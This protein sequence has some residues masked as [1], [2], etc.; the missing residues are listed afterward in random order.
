MSL[1]GVTYQP[2]LQQARFSEVEPAESVAE[3][4]RQVCEF[5]LNL[6]QCPGTPEQLIQDSLMLKR[7][8]LTLVEGLLEL[9]KAEEVRLLTLAALA[10]GMFAGALDGALLFQHRQVPQQPTFATRRTHL[11]HPTSVLRQNLEQVIEVGRTNWGR[12]EVNDLQLLAG[13]GKH[14]NKDSLKEAV[15]LAGA[16]QTTTYDFQGFLL[17]S[18]KGGYAMG[19]ADAAIVF[20]GGERPGAPP[21]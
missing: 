4:Y 5:L 6:E 8:L 10:Q 17:A 11:K 12:A 9:P 2:S 7:E 18:F 3:L 16:S 14:Q 19:V 13:Y 1:G 21:Q 20:V 15:E